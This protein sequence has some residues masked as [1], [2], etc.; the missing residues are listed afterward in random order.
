M[1]TN[2]LLAG[3]V[4]ATVGTVLVYPTLRGQ[5]AGVK[6]TPTTVVTPPS[7]PRTSTKRVEVVFVLD[8]T[9]SMGGLI[10]AAKE[11]IWSIA[12]TLAQARQAPEISMGLVAYRDRGDQ[13]V[14]QVI[15]LNKDLDS[16]YAKLMEFR[17]DGGGDTPES[18]NQGLDDAINKISWSQDAN[19]YRVVFLVGDA[20]PHMD[21]QDDVKYP[22]T[23]AAAAAK[24]IVVNTIQCGAM[25]ETVK[26]WQEI[27]ALGHGRYFT[28]DQ[29]GS[30]VAIDTPF[31]AKMAT[32]SA[33][34]DATRLYY[35]SA[36]EQKAMT[37]KLEASARLRA[38]A[39]PAAQARRGE[40]NA[41]AAGASNF[42]GGKDLVDD[43][44]SGRVELD[45][46]PAAELPP[47]IA[48]LPRAE[49]EVVVG[50]AATKR[51]DLQRQI[52]EL[53]KER[54]AFIKQKLGETGRAAGSLDQKIYD[55]VR[56]QAAP[57]GLVY[58]GGPKF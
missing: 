46:V 27:A 11:K 41:S 49:Q 23:V 33:E 25:R 35:G 38:A 8:T 48:A 3:L 42:L 26:P 57:V 18:V 50:G 30:A 43:V 31:D 53:A 17:A 54:D 20:P 40:F 28:V 9:G 22:T 21:Y 36:D 15:D 29:A 16:M 14:T 7:T 37:G 45:K 19:T 44:V 10:A 34:L 32:L 55:A 6:V 24:G 1:K 39:S 13:Y 51:Q 47:A 4:L 56:E 2:I 52:A 58:D 5:A 12:S